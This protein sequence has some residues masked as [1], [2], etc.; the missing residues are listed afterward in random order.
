LNDYN[1]PFEHPALKSWCYRLYNSRESP[2]FER[3]IAL[4]DIEIVITSESFTAPKDWK[5]IFSGNI[6]P[7]LGKYFIWKVPF[8]EAASLFPPGFSGDLQFASLPARLSGR[9]TTLNWESNECTISLGGPP[10][11]EGTILFL[12]WTPLKGW[13]AYVNGEQREF[14]GNKSFGLYL[15][16]PA[17]IREIRLLYRQPMFGHSII[18][19]ILGLIGI[20][21]AARRIRQA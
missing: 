16:L 17:E 2:N 21:N 20:I 8:F 19:M 9:S 10:V 14:I 13:T 7:N 3:L 6:P 5:P 11:P 18:I 4:S 1:P 15:T 12:P